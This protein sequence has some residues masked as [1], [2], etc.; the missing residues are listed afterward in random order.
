MLSVCYFPPYSYEY[1]I[2]HQG[3]TNRSDIEGMYMTRSDITVKLIVENMNSRDTVL[4]HRQV[5]PRSFEHDVL[6]LI[7]RHE[8]P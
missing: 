3:D 8:M 5:Q 7:G 4:T 2:T 1:V 6:N